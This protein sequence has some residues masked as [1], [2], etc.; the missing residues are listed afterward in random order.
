MPKQYPRKLRERVVLL[1]AEHRGDYESE[2]AAI[3]S[4]SAPDS[5]QRFSRQSCP[6]RPLTL[7]YVIS[8]YSANNEE[9]CS[10]R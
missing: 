10:I 1:V 7:Q 5:G 3:R 9:S 4:R 2:Y 8:N 6:G